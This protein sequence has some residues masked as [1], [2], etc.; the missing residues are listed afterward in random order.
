[1]ST[2]RE[3]MQRFQASPAGAGDGPASDLPPD[4]LLRLHSQHYAERLTQCSEAMLGYELAWLEQHREALDVCRLQPEMLQAA[5]G[6]RRLQRLEQ[7]TVLFERALASELTQRRL[8]P[9]PQRHAVVANEHA[10]ELTHPGIR[11]AWG[12]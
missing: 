11:Q 8:I 12:I 3:I 5:G 1:M 9:K 7:E 4:P 2:L 10:W 6:A